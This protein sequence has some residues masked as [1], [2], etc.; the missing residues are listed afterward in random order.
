L[1]CP[2]YLY[3][4][5][6]G[7]YYYYC[8]CCTVPG[9]H[10]IV[11]TPTQI[12]SQLPILC[13]DPSDDCFIIDPGIPTP[14]RGDSGD[15]LFGYNARNSVTG[16]PVATSYINGI[17]PKDAQALHDELVSGAANAGLDVNGLGYA[18]YVDSSGVAHTVA[19]Y[20][21]S[22]QNAPC[23]VYVG[24]DVTGSPVGKL[25]PLAIP[26]VF[27]VPGYPHYNRVHLTAGGPVYHVATKK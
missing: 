15:C 22:R 27:E 4:V 25:K 23:P 6:N 5:A 11:P 19:L 10:P 18:K 14:D 12:E 21:L 20:D 8:Q 3:A 2:Q 16:A 1:A 7:I 9:Q 24:Q 17:D 26:R 13:T